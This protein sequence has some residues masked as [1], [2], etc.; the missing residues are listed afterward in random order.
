M[1]VCLPAP[2]LSVLSSPK[3]H[4]VWM[5]EKTQG[6]YNDGACLL[7]FLQNLGSRPKWLCLPSLFP[8]PPGMDT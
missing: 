4:K 7:A 3:Q 1:G 2:E 6:A 8:K 5:L